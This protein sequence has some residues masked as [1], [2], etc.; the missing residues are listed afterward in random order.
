M[1]ECVFSVREWVSVCVVAGNVCVLD[2][3]LVLCVRVY[4]VCV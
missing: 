4:L 1:G 2:Y 3:V